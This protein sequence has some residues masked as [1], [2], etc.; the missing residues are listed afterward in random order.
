MN[1]ASYLML[2]VLTA[3][4]IGCQL[5]LPALNIQA[6]FRGSRFD[7]ES[8]LLRADAAVA[9]ADRDRGQVA[10]LDGKLESAAVAVAMGGV[11]LRPGHLII[12]R[13]TGGEENKCGR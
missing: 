10:Q 2:Y 1:S 3:E 8:P 4:L 9:L 7:P 13:Q 5:L 12:G 11:F 6:T